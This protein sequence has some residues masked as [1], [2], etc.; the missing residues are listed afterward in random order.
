MSGV[1]WPILGFPRSEGH[2]H[3]AASAVGGYSEDKGLEQYVV[4][5]EMLGIA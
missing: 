1:L 4:Y 2:C 5:K 3:T